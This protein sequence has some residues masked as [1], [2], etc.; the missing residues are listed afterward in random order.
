MPIPVALT[1]KFVL[2]GD[3]CG[4]AF[5]CTD[6][7]QES[8]KSTFK[9]GTCRVSYLTEKIGAPLKLY[10]SFLLEIIQPIFSYGK[11]YDRAMHVFSLALNRIS[12]LKVFL[13]LFL[14]QHYSHLNHLTCGT[15]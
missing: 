15:I 8:L 14:I 3:I 2:C 10:Y 5:K 6:Y 1:K 12:S 11:S 9:F 7:I 4:A 13:F